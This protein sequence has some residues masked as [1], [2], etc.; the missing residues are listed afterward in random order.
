MG[1]K[2]VKLDGPYIRWFLVQTDVYNLTFVDL[3]TNEYYLNIFVGI[4]E[5]KKSTN[6]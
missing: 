1:S 5:F 6:D 4:D 2:K 3:G